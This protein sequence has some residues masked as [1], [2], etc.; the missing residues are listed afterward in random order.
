MY[1]DDLDSSQNDSCVV[2]LELRHNSFADVFAFLSV[3]SFISGKSVEDSNSTPF[4]AF[5]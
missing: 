4:R 1:H 3:L 5:I 2:M